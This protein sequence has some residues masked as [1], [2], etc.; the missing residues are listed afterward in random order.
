MSTEPSSSPSSALPHSPDPDES[1]SPFSIEDI[2]RL[3]AVFEVHEDIAKMS[4]QDLSDAVINEVW[5]KLRFCS[6]QDWLL[7]EMIA[8]FDKRCG[9]VRGEEDG[10]V[11]ADDISE[12]ATKIGVRICEKGH[13]WVASGVPCYLCQ[14]AQQ[15]ALTA[16]RNAAL[17]QREEYRRRLALVHEYLIAGWKT[18]TLPFGM[19][20]ELI[21]SLNRPV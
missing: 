13:G 5:A 18:N 6:R 17:Q 16:E 8:R 19:S 14:N 7:D 4:D 1:L 3:A 12:Q 10:E 20:S 15:E 11:V 21:D 2:S 9:I